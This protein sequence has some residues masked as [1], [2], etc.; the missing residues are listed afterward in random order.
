MEHSGKKKYDLQGSAEKS[1]SK[2]IINGKKYENISINKSINQQITRFGK[3]EHIIFLT[4]SK[5]QIPQS[6]YQEQLKEKKRLDCG[7]P[8]SFDHLLTI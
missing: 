1:N 6:I 2:K 5:D 4:K 3:S 8:R 7:V